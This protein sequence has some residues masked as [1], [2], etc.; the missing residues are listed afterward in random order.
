MPDLFTANERRLHG[1]DN[2]IAEGEVI[3]LRFVE[4]V[5]LAE[6]SDADG[7]VVRRHEWYLQ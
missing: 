4:G 6:P 7:D 2:C 5:F 1:I 3:F